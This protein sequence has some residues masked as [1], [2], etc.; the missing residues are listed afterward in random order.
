MGQK[1]V[2]IT[3][4][5]VLYGSIFYTEGLRAVVGVTSGI[6]ENTVDLLYPG[7]GVPAGDGAARALFCSGLIHCGDHP[8]RV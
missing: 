6:D 8:R 3:F 7:D 4:N 2:L 5:R 1:H